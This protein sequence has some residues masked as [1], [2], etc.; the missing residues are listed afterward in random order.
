MPTTRRDTTAFDVLV[1]D[2][3]EDIRELLVEYFQN[4]GL[5]VVAAAE[6]QAAIDAVERDPSRFGLIVTDLQLPDTDGLSVLRAARMANPSVYV[7]IV[8]GY[9]SLESAI[10]AVRLG[11]YDYL[12]KPFSVGQIDVIVQRVR[13]RLALEAENRR[14][15]RQMAGRDGM[16]SRGALTDRL[17]AIEGRLGHVEELLRELVRRAD[18]TRT[19]SPRSAS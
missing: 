9:A 3:E 1:V 5:P 15:L 11:A 16:E 19:L 10:Q 4:A 6:G 8:T 14:L 12:A 17:D 7:V 2:D 18:P 13:D